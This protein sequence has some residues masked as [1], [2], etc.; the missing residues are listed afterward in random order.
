MQSYTTTLQSYLQKSNYVLDLWSG[1]GFLSLV[2]A[3]YGAKVIAIDNTSMTKKFQP[4]PYLYDHPNITFYNDEL[5]NIEL[6]KNKQFDCIILS[7]VII[8]LDKQFFLTTLLPQLLSQLSEHGV[9]YLNYFA[10]DDFIQQHHATS[11]YTREDFTQY[12]I[13]EEFEEQ[14][15]RDKEKTNISHT[16]YIF[17]KEKN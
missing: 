3:S 2:A 1:T 5:S 17:L 6:Y 16:H 9:I 12:N 15:R 14:N 11:F 7:Y 10:E 13:I 4:S 8:F